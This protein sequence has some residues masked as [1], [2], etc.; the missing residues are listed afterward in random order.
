MSLSRP[1]PRRA[2]GSTLILTVILLMVLAV[3]GVAAVSLG[4]QE[5]INASGKTQRDQLYAC[6]AAARMQI[7]AELARY[8]RGYLESGNVAGSVTLP[9]G[10]VLTAPSHYDSDPDVT[11][12][13]VVLKNTVTTASTPTATDLTNSFNFMQGLNTATGYTV[14]AKCK[15]RRGRPLEVEFVTAIIL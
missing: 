12:S 11:V 2:S 5:R 10:T 6:A 15:D 7:W 13:S 14:V 3:I 1:L 4:S 9:D 8:G